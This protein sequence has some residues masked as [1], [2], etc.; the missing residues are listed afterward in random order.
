VGSR[1]PHGEEPAWWT[2]WRE[3]LAT[4]VSQ[5]MN[6]A[7]D[8][9]HVLW[10]P[11]DMVPRMERDPARAAQLMLADMDRSDEAGTRWFLADRQVQDLPPR[12]G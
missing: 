2:L 1:A 7:L 8:T 3:G 6:P 12:A 11:R 4:Y 10:Y 5:R 9:R